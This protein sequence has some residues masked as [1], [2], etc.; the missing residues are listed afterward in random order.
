M[1]A[2]ML[3]FLTS[4]LGFCLIVIGVLFGEVYGFVH[5]TD[6]FGAADIFALLMMAAGGI[7]IVWGILL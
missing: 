3:P 7:L 5:H 4:I 2:V 1:T 6:K